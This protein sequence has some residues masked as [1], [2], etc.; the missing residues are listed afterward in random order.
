MDTTTV[1]R[2]RYAEV[3]V[4]GLVAY[5]CFCPV[6]TL[7]QAFCSSKLSLQK[8]SVLFTKTH[9]SPCIAAH[10]TC[11]NADTKSGTRELAPISTS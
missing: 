1:M 7:L 3:Q 11:S 2:D 8:C 5:R 10:G 4:I 6:G 9:L